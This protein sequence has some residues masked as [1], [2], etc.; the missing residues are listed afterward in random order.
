MRVVDEH[1]G[2]A[3]RCPSSVNAA[4]R[5][6]GRR[7]PERARV[8]MT[9]CVCRINNAGKTKGARQGVC[10]CGA[11]AAAAVAAR[12]AIYAHSHATQKG[13]RVAVVVYEVVFGVVMGV[14][15]L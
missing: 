5:K 3:G 14:S 11:A 4:L 7:G 13:G 10:C 8:Y 6:K 1:K 9:S 12:E 15:A 2:G